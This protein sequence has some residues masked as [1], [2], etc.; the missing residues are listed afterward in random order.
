MC[1]AENKLVLDLLAERCL[2]SHGITAFANSCVY[3]YNSMLGL[4][5][6]REAAAYFLARHFLCLGQKKKK[7]KKN[8]NKNKL[9]DNP[10]HNSTTTT[11][12]TTTKN[13]E[14]G[15][16]NNDNNDDDFVPFST[17]EALQHI[18][19]KCI[20]FGAG[21]AA[22]LNHVFFLLGESNDICLIPKPYYAAFENDI[23][24][25]AQII[26]FGIHQQNPKLGPTNNELQ[27]AYQQ[28]Q[29]QYNGT[30][31][32]FL[33]LTNPNNPLGIIY[34]SN[35]ICSCIQWARQHG[36]HIIMDEIYALSIHPI[37]TT[38]TTTTTTTSSITQ[39]K[40]DQQQ[41]KQQQEQE[42]PQHTF[43]SVISILDNELGTDIHVLWA[44]SKDFGASGL[45]C[46]LI[47]TQNEVLMEGLATLSIFTCVSGPI[48][49][50]IS[51]V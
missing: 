3:T 8:K 28:V 4:P 21:C 50:R 35:V 39:D 26:P 1:V 15:D 9:L 41:Q 7:N 20:G 45:R 5:I 34:T 51:Y 48:Q 16:T 18:P 17:E 12:T 29:Q 25:M 43:E 37:T 27:N 40:N 46:G 10:I 32:K 6:A 31:P 14:T 13:D 33:L 44:I 42:Q 22:L 38:T 19:P 2:Q 30:K 11:T 36:M 49:V 23:Q 47:Y 24:L